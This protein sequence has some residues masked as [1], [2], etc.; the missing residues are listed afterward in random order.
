MWQWHYNGN[1]ADCTPENSLKLTARA[2]QPSLEP[3]TLTNPFGEL[4]GRPEDGQMSFRMVGDTN[5]VQTAVRQGPADAHESP[6]YAVIER[7]LRRILPYEAGRA[8][9]ADGQ[10]SKTRKEVTVGTEHYVAVRGRLY[11]R[12]NGELRRARWKRTNVT[13]R[14]YEKRTA[15]RFQW[16]FKGAFR[17]ERMRAAVAQVSAELDDPSVLEQAFD[18]FDPELD[19]TE[20]GPYQFG[21]FLVS[22]DLHELAVRV[23]D[24]YHTAEPTEWRAFDA[25]TNA[26][27]EKGRQDGRPIAHIMVRGHQY[28]LIFDSGSGASGQPPVV[29]RPLRYERILTAIEENFGRAQMRTLFDTLLELGVNPQLFI[30]AVMADV[31]AIDQYVPPE[32]RTRIRAL[33]QRESASTALQEQLPP[34]LEKYKECDVRLSAVETLAPKPLQPAVKQTLVTGLRVPD[35]LRAHCE[36][37][38]DLVSFIHKHQAWDVGAGNHTCDIC[39]AKTVVL[40]GHCGSAKACLKCWVDSLQS[41]QMHC[42]FCRQEVCETQLTVVT[43]APAPAPRAP[44]KR[45]RRQEYANAEQALAQIRQDKMYAHYKLDDSQP[46]RKWFTV[47][48]R[49]GMLKNGRLPR[50]MQAKKSLRTALQEFNILN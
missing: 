46:M 17:W 2:A 32:A 26:M 14:E 42:P 41:T 18:A 38:G 36:S 11:S 9:F 29:V 21:D 4:V 23:M 30:M 44:K 28:A 33:L 49:T 19:L 37:F 24:A 13:R 22:R 27:I 47:L 25:V 31:G 1:W 50:N 5:Y 20:H 7:S 16:E 48:M 40:G 3:I 6:M 39:A 8:L 43:A 12:F 35:Q 45:K 34:L 10:P 15:T